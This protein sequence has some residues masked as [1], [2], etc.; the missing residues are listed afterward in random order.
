MTAPLLSSKAG[1]LRALEPHVTRA[2][3]LPQASFT[4]AQWRADTDAAIALV[5]TTLG[6]DGPL[7][8]R[9]SAR[10]EDG[11]A[12]SMAGAFAS[13]LDVRGAAAVR[14]ATREV[15]A[16]YGPDPDDDDAVLIQP[17]LQDVAFSGVAFT[18]DPTTGAPYRVL[19]LQRGSDTT[20]VTAGTDAGE[21]FVVAAGR[22]EAP[23]DLLPILD[24]LEELER[25]IP[26]QPLDIEFAVCGDEGAPH[27]YLLQARPLVLSITNAAMPRD[28]HAKILD[29]IATRIADGQRAHPYLRGRSTVYGVMPDW[30]P[31]EIIGTRPRPLALSLYRDLLTDRTW[32]YQRHNYGYRNLRSFPLL[33]SFAG[34]PYVDVRLS[35]NSFIPGDLDEGIADR[36]VDHYI[37]R[38]VQAPRLHDKIEF[39]IVF[40]CYTLDLPERIKVLEQAGFSGRERKA[41]QR[42]LRTLTNRVIEQKRGLW[43]LDAQKID[44]LGQRHDTVAAS[45]LTPL[46]RIYWLLEDCK[47]YGT[48]PF[49]GL[50]RA[51]FIA[52]QML[53]SL[54]ATGVFS[55]ADYD[56]FMR[57]VDTVSGQFS[58]DL[59][60]L[61][62][63]SF[64]SRYGHLRPGTY[65]IRSPRYDER[66]D[67]YLGDRDRGIGPEHGGDFGLSLAQMRALRSLLARHKLSVDVVELMEFL[68]AGI[69]MREYA[70]FVF[71][72]NLSDAMAIFADWGKSLGF[73]AEDLSYA[74][75]GV[76]TELNACTDDPSE[77]IGHSIEQGRR[78]YAETLRVWLPPVITDPRQVY[79]FQVSESEPN[80]VTQREVTGPVVQLRPG[81]TRTTGLEGAIVF[82][83]S[84]DPGYDWLFSHA[85]G[86]LVTAFGGANSHMAIRAGELQLPA[87]IGA[88]EVIFERWAKA[89]RLHI[90]CAGRRIERIS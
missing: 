52:V 28:D 76:V 4:V 45:D 70:K 65:D 30:N 50:A 57:S 75:I 78:R 71:S 46:E 69:E 10:N 21:T 64:L 26:D 56:G 63:S 5:E 61:D 16:S 38:L 1:T 32:A 6:C 18:H 79:G 3:I 48:L 47:R 8:V 40:S 80:F 19:S 27:L 20:A 84:A 34:Q 87:V 62:R 49:A 83:P 2:R 15:I 86:G 22:R 90:D 53:R 51:G 13:I 29:K 44:I 74:N 73:S 59:V 25:L 41:L 77:V 36:L 42:S 85:I 43:R 68:H 60:R 14:D 54:V 35:F 7:I 88:G 24:L 72:R 89:Q 55:Q 37:D 23:E 58:R 31:A 82:I 67:L 81:E 66:P 9:S 17:M 11:P 12:V 33:Q 39:E